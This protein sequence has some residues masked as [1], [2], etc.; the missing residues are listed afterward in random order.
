MMP[1]RQVL[2]VFLKDLRAL[3]FMASSIV[4]LC[5]IMVVAGTSDWAVVYDRQTGLSFL[6]SRIGGALTNWSSILLPVAWIALIHELIR[7]DTPTGRSPWWLTRPASRFTILSAKLLFL[8]IFVHAALL[9]SQWIILIGSGLPVSLESLSINQLI[10]AA[11]MT[12]PLT[13][14][15]ALTRTIWSYLF[16]GGLVAMFALFVVSPVGTGAFDSTIGYFLDTQAPRVSYLIAWHWFEVCV[17]LAGV[18]IIS[19]VA[20]AWQ[21]RYRHTRYV[22]AAGAGSLAMIAGILLAIPDSLAAHADRQLYGVDVDPPEF[23]LAA[24]YRYGQSLPGVPPNPGF[25]VVP[26]RPDRGP[27][28]FAID[29]SIDIDIPAN[30]ALWNRGG[31]VS[32]QSTATD[33]DITV[34]AY[35]H[36]YGELT[37]LHFAIPADVYDEIADATDLRLEA[38]LQFLRYDETIHRLPAI[39]GQELII[40]NDLQCGFMNTQRTSLHCR[41][42]SIGRY[43]WMNSYGNLSGSGNRF[44]AR[45]GSRTLPF[46]IYP[47]TAFHQL[48]RTDIFPGVASS[49]DGRSHELRLLT[50]GSYSTSRL[51]I[52][53]FALSDWMWQD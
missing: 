37:V 13:L 29:L 41:S 14:I 17:G 27:D 28:R 2:H 6:Y 33:Q 21:Y 20:I 10:L 18:A 19:S 8:A 23:R 38:E 40:D 1:V 16:A 51:V 12:L 9:V 44:E 34:D 47:V 30:G 50:P 22:A 7:G 32:L 26:T 35:L 52:D 4:L 42:G 45:R 11:I 31:Q 48:P 36:R 24:P 39:A 15:A 3:R 25:M 53:E 49:A 43:Q 5:L 46:S